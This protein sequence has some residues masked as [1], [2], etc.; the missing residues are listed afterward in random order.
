MTTIRTTVVLLC[1]G[2]MIVPAFQ[3]V[4]G[5]LLRPAP[6]SNNVP[7]ARNEVPS[8]F[9][10]LPALVADLLNTT[11]NLTDTDKDK[12][13]DNVERVI[14]TDWNNSDSDNDKLSDHFEVFH[15]MDP[16][17]PDSNGDHLPDYYEVT[18][19]PSDL[20]GDG[21][22]NAWDWD[23][24]GDGIMDDLDLSPF[25]K[26]AMSSS[27]TLDMN[28]SGQVTYITFQLRPKNPDHMRLY[29][30]VWDWQNDDTLGT[31]RDLDGS[32]QDLRISPV[33]ELRSSNLP[34]QKSL[35]DFGITSVDDT[36]YIPVYPLYEFGNL[37]ALQ[38]R[39][40]YPQAGGPQDV[41]ADLKLTW[42]VT[43]RTDTILTGITGPDGKYLSCDEGGNITLDAKTKDADQTFEYINAG[44]G[45]LSFRGSN[46]LY[47]AIDEDGLVSASAQAPGAESIFTPMNDSGKILL[48]AG[49]GKYLNMGVDRKL[50][51]VETDWR[52]AVSFEM[53]D[54]S[55]RYDNMQFVKYYEDFMLAGLRMEEN[56]GVKA[57]VFFDNDMNMTVAANLVLAYDFLRNASY[58]LE[59]MPVHLKDYSIMVQSNI[60][61]FS[62]TDPAVAALAHDMPVDALGRI[63]SFGIVPL[64]FAM[65]DRSK[66]LDLSNGSTGSYIVG[67]HLKL[68]FKAEPVI[69][70]RSLKTT[71]YDTLTLK[72]L[73]VTET[74]TA[75]QGWDLSESAKMAL[76]AFTVAWGVGEQTVVRIGASPVDYSSTFQ[77]RTNVNTLWLDVLIIGMEG[78]ELTV[79]V[80]LRIGAS[81]WVKSP[82]ILKTLATKA[83]VPA[84]KS[85]SETVEAMSKVRT[86]F[87]KVINIGAKALLIVGTI[88]DVILIGYTVWAIGQ[89]YGWTPTGIAV[90]TA[91]GLLMAI[92]T[93]ALLFMAIAL[94]PVGTVISILIALSDLI[95]FFATGSSWSS[96]LINAA[97][98]FLQDKYSQIR[99]R[100]TLDLKV[101]DAD[102]GIMDQDGNGV[103]AGDIITFTAF[104]EGLVYKSVNGSDADLA[105]SY[106]RPDFSVYVPSYAKAETSSDTEQVSE[107]TTNMKSTTYKTDIMVQP[108][109]GVVNMPVVINITT[110]YK[111]YYSDCWKFIKWWCERKDSTGSTASP[112]TVLNFDVMPG[113]INELVNWTALKSNDHDGDMI[114]DTDEK[115]TSPWKADTDGDGLGDKYELELGTNPALADTDGDGLNDR[116]ELLQGTSNSNNDSDADGL[117]DGKEYYGYVISFNFSGKT[118]HWRVTSDPNHNDTDGD[119]VKDLYELYT[120][121]NPRSQDTNGDGTQDGLN[122]LYDFNVSYDMT[123][124][125]PT[126]WIA[127]PTLVK[128]SPNGNIYVS[129]NN[130]T[131]VKYDA[132]GTVLKIK[133]IGLSIGFMNI[134][135]KGKIY[136]SGLVMGSPFVYVLDANLN[137]LQSGPTSPELVS[138]V[139]DEKH[140]IMFAT[141]IT[142]G[143]FKYNISTL[144]LIGSNPLLN[145][146]Y[147]IKGMDLLS[148]GDILAAMRGN[149]TGGDL[150]TRNDP[151]GSGWTTIGGPGTGN[152]QF[153]QPWDVSVLP[154][155]YVIVAERGNN[156]IQILDI[157]GEWRTTFGGTAP[158]SGNAN[159]NQP[160]SVAHDEQHI[161]VL[162]YNNARVQKL[163][164]VRF[165]EVD[166]QK[167]NFTDADGDGFSDKNETKGWD[168]TATR[169][170]SKA[171]STY[172]V[173]SEPNATDTDGDG[174]SDLR[175]FSLKT[176]PRSPDSDGDGLGDGA[177]VDVYGTDP[178]DYDSDRDGLDDSSEMTFGSDPKKK[179]SDGDGL[180]DLDEQ[181]LGSDPNAK[182]SDGDGLDD[183]A[184]KDAKTDPS[185]PDSD[186]DLSGDGEEMQKGTDP[187]KGDMDSDGLPDGYENLSGTDP[188]DSDSDNDGLTD[189]T[190]VELGLNPLS[191][192]TDHDGVTDK[193]ELDNGLNPF[194]NDTDGNGVPDGSEISSTV[195][196]DE[197]I[198][199]VMDPSDVAEAF[200]TA[201]KNWATVE[202]VTPSEL[203]AHHTMF[204]DIVL[205]GTPNAQA[206]NGTTG[207]LIRELLL[208]TVALDEMLTPGQNIV[209][210][211]GVWT[212]TQ[213]VVMINGPGTYDHSKV[214]GMLKS[215]KMTVTDTSVRAEFREA[216]CCAQLDE[217][218]LVRATDTSVWLKL[219]QPRAFNM[220]VSRYNGATSLHTMDYDHGLVRGDVAMSK[221]IGIEL[222]QNVWSDTTDLVSGASIRIY[223]EGADLG[224]DMNN[225]GAIENNE[226]L[227]ESTLELY[228]FDELTGNWTPLSATPDWVNG[229][230][231]N[232]TDV[233]LNGKDYWGYLWADVSHLSLFGIGGEVLGTLSSVIAKA[234]KAQNI[235]VFEDVL[236]NGSLSSGNG[237]LDYSWTM[238]YWSETVTQDGPL[239]QF[240]FD[241][242]GVYE[243]RLTVEDGYGLTATDNVTVTVKDEWVLDLGPV[244][245]SNGNNISGALVTLDNGKA[246]M[247]ALTDGRGHVRL[248]MNVSWIGANVSVRIEKAGYLRGDMGSKITASR[249][250][251]DWLPVLVKVVLPKDFTLKV[252]PLK[253]KKGKVLTGAFVTMTVN[254][255]TYVNITD[256]TGVTTF[257]LPRTDIGLQ[258]IIMVQLSGYKKTQ[259][260]M[261]L[262]ESGVPLAAMKRSSPPSDNTPI[263]VA[264]I[265]I[266]V[267]AVLLV[268]LFIWSKSRGRKEE[269]STDMDEGAAKPTRAVRT[270]KSKSDR[271]AHHTMDAE[272]EPEDGMEKEV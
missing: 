210:R 245:D 241:R 224:V 28:L 255:T 181:M 83:N 86:G 218:D 124:K 27:Y 188:K 34:A 88:L 243:V 127:K 45:N 244:L 212:P 220:T 158:G 205:V 79:D 123:I 41:S 260:T 262:T 68:D 73:D 29:S 95:T 90:A 247:S 72:P 54:Q 23:N 197:T 264:G 39:M 67:S 48:K 11:T 78:L 62:H 150:L 36:A 121:Q 233:T 164:Y 180:N 126:G 168:V 147:T 204:P 7:S 140:G 184:E 185:D 227:N 230:G 87:L 2:L 102:T 151:D 199:L 198:V 238:A 74:V 231:V 157:S 272:Q 192:D 268:Q 56:H 22:P 122:A 94:A 13:P 129:F 64:I 267:G 202:V 69:T 10:S 14:G 99:V 76:I 161:Y 261:T 21:V 208:G 105:D 257:L 186:D 213:T 82:T 6:V 92:Y 130:Q 91:F 256:A 229:T 113:T 58:E 200:A 66:S 55:T 201:L 249:H 109:R 216:Q 15:G 114:N 128:V 179:D 24:D 112:W 46:G 226:A 132:N 51:A 12:L 153:N 177:E 138:F 125:P 18:G 111:A 93:G 160:M 31:I 25:S 250:L 19:V 187:N 65:E 174:L 53:V 232:T 240:V 209:V 222:S 110:N 228:V 101:K 170:G 167:T 107:T 146:G 193:Q 162:D 183:N 236:L 211:Y 9:L 47:L 30:Q 60:T 134:D 207:A 265:L 269:G 42:E 120:L 139:L 156:R 178:C 219:D 33:L 135:S 182:D 254:G 214:M 26:G 77:E 98:K 3:P 165:I 108:G 80:F 38:A 173:T 259:Q 154:D 169:I 131:M 97:V 137:L 32:T 35:L 43:G 194:S 191:N 195:E 235:S 4:L 116:L 89:A 172:H 159:F 206:E 196:L 234:G 71:W 221:Y 106:I 133:N 270:K 118:F 85:Y 117:P 141:T 252:G 189:G 63:S 171:T 115:T 84:I 217:M 253:D 203:L 143:M 1:I 223:Y 155:D 57:G 246:N 40:V 17:N 5:E 175:E 266:A 163:D 104:L 37:V 242:P 215:K 251:A 148:N 142:P 271:A 152:G 61:S 8:P 103:D 248:T 145:T 50:Q 119:G 44:S 144:S 16:N 239:F 59:D 166:K 176:D 52:Y 258:A 190:E 263:I 49:N 70:T 81:Y 100:S 149:V 136:A 75:M 96:K 225:D 237:P 20:D